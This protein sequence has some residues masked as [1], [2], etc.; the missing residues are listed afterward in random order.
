MPENFDCYPNTTLPAS[1]FEPRT[2]IIVTDG[3]TVKKGLDRRLKRVSLLNS[4]YYT[5]FFY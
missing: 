2:A 4:N 1:S 5:Y 3:T